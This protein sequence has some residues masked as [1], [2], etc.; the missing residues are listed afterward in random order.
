MAEALLATDSGIADSIRMGDDR[1][2][3]DFDEDAAT[4]ER[5]DE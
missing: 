1:G 4:V 5:P 3:L 2:A